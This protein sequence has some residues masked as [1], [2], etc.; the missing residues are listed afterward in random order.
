MCDYNYFS[1]GLC[2]SCLDCQD[3]FN[4]SEDDILDGSSISSFGCDICDNYLQQTLH[5]A[6]YRDENDNICHIDIC[7]ECFNEF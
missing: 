6:H 7:E 3:T 1:S 2:S 5:V 4:C